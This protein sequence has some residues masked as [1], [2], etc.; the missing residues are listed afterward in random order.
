MLSVTDPAREL[1]DACERLSKPSNKRGDDHLAEHFSVPTWSTEFF[2]IIFCLSERADQL[3]EIINNLEI[4]EDYKKDALIHIRHIKKA[5]SRETMM[6]TWHQQGITYL[7]RENIQPI[8]M[9]S[10]LVRKKISYPKLDDSEIDEVLKLTDDLEKW[11]SKHQLNEQ[12]F[13]RQ[14]ILDGIR[15]FRFR[16]ERI[17]WLGWGYTVA[18]LR[19]IIGAYL[20]LER[21]IVPN[22]T[23]DS[24][25][26]LKKAYGSLRKIYEKIGILKDVSNTGEFLLKAYGAA[27]LVMDSRVIAGLLSHAD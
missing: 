12:D 2:Q 24:E 9:L 25:A 15:Q 21:G 3:G 6:H 14:A 19:D 20:A 17:G 7:S 26:V 16:L 18:S 22:K 1:A 10:P 27:S 5:F 23:P 13:I 11:L 4:D 8:K